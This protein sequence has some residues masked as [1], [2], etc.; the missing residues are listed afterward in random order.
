MFGHVNWARRQI[1]H[2]IFTEGYLYIVVFIGG[3][4]TFNFY[5]FKTFFFLAKE[6]KP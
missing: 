6:S 1:T 2:S 4:D 3:S 5:F